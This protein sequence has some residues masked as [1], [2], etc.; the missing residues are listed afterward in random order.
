M[1][2]SGSDIQHATCGQWL[3]QIPKKI[4]RIQ[5]DSRHFKHGDVFL[6]LRG[7]HFDG[8]AFASQVADKASALIGDQ[9]GMKSWSNFKK[10]K[11]EVI[12]TLC[13]LG[14]IAHAWR[15]KLTNT[16]IIAITGSYGKTT[17]RSMLVHAFNALSIKT[18]ATHANLNNLIGVPMTLL[19]I[20]KDTEIAL[21]ECGISEIGEMQRLSEIV[22]PDIAILTGIT[23]AHAEGLGGLHGVAYEKSLLLNYLSPQG[24]CAL[25]QGVHEQLPAIQHESIETFV[26]WQLQ[27]NELTLSYQGDSSSLTL[28][29]P[30]PHWGS[31]MAFVCSIVMHHLHQQERSVSLKELT[32]ILASWQPVE[33][34]LQS[35]SGINS[36]VVLDDSYN[37]NPISMQAALHTLAAMPERRIA[38][39]GDM[40][41]LGA[42]AEKAHKQLDVSQTDV[43][44]LIGAYMHALHQQ[45]PESQWFTD[46]DALLTWL[47]EQQNMFTARDTI[48]I[49]ASHSMQLYRVVSLLTEPENI[50]V[51]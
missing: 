2:L 23:S 19:D 5:T 37:A 3:N 22:Q 8:H 7:P 17:V 12:D 40:A 21:V 30:A 43:L 50:H 29:L 33:G 35:L 18:A 27:D 9:Q 32:N 47:N 15:K 45:H 51:I 42:D 34:R 16:T 24:W 4:G 41:E 48:L 20:A 25:G 31:N 26:D 38:M 49:K 28:A 14:D 46:T 1:Y 39:I 13:A 10:P 36:C 6:A 11:L 44:I